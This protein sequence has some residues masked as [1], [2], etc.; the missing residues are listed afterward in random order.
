MTAPTDRPT[1][2]VTWTVTGV[3]G[4]AP[5]EAVVTFV[6]APPVIRAAAPPVTLLS[7]PVPVELDEAGALP[8][9]VLLSTDPEGWTWT[10][11]LRVRGVPR[12][13][14]TFRLPAGA[15]IDLTDEAPVSMDRGT[16]MLR[17]PQ[18]ET[19]PAGPPGPAGADGA[20]GQDG[21]DAVLPERLS[22]DALRA[23][24]GSPDRYLAWAQLDRQ[25]AGALAASSGRTRVAWEAATE[26][27]EDWADLTGLG[28]ANVTVNSNRLTRAASAPAP[29][30]VKIPWTIGAR[31]GIAQAVL[32]LTTRA[33]GDPNLFFGVAGGAAASIPAS[34]IPD[35]FLIGLRGTGG[36]VG[37]LRGSSIGGTGQADLG[38]GVAPVGKYLATVAVDEVNVS[39]SLRSLTTQEEWVRRVARSAFDPVGGVTNLVAYSSLATA[40]VEPV[41]AI[42]MPS[43]VKT[44]TIAGYTVGGAPTVIYTGT[45]D[46]VDNYRIQLPENYDPRVPTPLVIWA[47]NNSGTAISLA[48]DV[49]SKPLMDALASAGYI[50]ASALAS[51]S[52]WGNDTSRAQ[53]VALYEFVRAHYGISGV[54]LIGQSMGGQTCLNLLPRR[55]IPNVTAYLSIAG[56]ANLDE[57]HADATYTAA[58]R[59]ALGVAS[60][61]SDYETKTAGYRPEDRAGWEFRGVPMM[62]VHSPTDAVC[63]LSSVQAVAA[64]AAP[65]APEAAV[66]QSTGAHMAA[67]QFTTAIASGIPF[68][69]K[70]LPV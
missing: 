68:L 50:V 33:N 45:A 15:E 58:I 57:L 59:T 16:P 4:T 70:Y 28:A 67:E 63:S 69:Q 66:V 2:T 18:G 5:G 25:G 31:G 52:A 32:D 26:T 11:Y 64:K 1:G 9:T 41:S 47:H 39:L 3:S 60:D 19:G 17:G 21:A 65:F 36:A 12:D 37:Y 30:A 51:G 46:L 56:V 62:F 49:R 13:S 7:E 43:K 8:P 44:K 53:Y 23:A 6:P 24:L 40:F 34:G 20:D 35:G 29:Q 22:E 55:E 54:A 48:S 38:T 27:I 14:V 42:N 10:A 61:G